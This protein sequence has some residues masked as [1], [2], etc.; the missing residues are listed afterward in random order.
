MN[1]KRDKYAESRVPHSHTIQP[2]IIIV[3]IAV[4][5]VSVSGSLN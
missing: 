5:T 2:E 4:D 1:L 3:S